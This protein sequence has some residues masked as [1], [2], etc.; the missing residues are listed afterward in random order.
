MIAKLP[1]LPPVPPPNKN[2]LS[3]Y[4]REN[5]HDLKR[6]SGNKGEV[7]IAAGELETAAAAALALA[8]QTETVKVLGTEH[9]YREK[10]IDRLKTRLK[11]L[12]DDLAEKQSGLA[13]DLGKALQ[14]K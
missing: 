10:L 4:I 2:L 14:K 5:S 7:H 8:P 13:D 6:R 11:S 1:E 9:E 3:A 12:L